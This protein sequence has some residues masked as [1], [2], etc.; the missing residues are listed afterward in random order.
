[1]LFGR[2][3][4]SGNL[5]ADKHNGASDNNCAARMRVALICSGPTP[6]VHAYISYVL[7]YDELIIYMYVKTVMDC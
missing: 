6:N 7:V 2:T 1:M 5:V 4:I 3:C